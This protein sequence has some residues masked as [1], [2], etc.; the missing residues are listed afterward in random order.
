MKSRVGRS[1]F[2]NVHCEKTRT[3][4]YAQVAPPP[5]E[6]RGGCPCSGSCST[7]FL[8]FLSFLSSVYGWRAYPPG[9]WCPASRIMGLL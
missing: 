3:G 1:R 6:A 5:P 2:V 8:S 7:S 9:K 4:L